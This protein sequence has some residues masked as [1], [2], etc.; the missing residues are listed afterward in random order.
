MS[1][2]EQELLR[3]ARNQALY[4][5]VN[6]RIEAVNEAFETLGVDSSWLC[7]CADPEC[8]EAM[9]LT[10]EEYEHLRSHPNRFAVLPGHV[11]PE[12]E[13]VV[14]EHENYVVVEMLGIGAT[15][16]EEHDPR[17]GATGDPTPSE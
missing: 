17:C 6:E 12:V 5:A 15:F 3:A 14:V 4:R 11:Y 1:D 13:R 7:E 8:T 2:A 16:V 9:E 10:L